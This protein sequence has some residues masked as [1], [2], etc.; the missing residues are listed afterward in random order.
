MSHP[1]AVIVG[2]VEDTGA[3]IY[4]CPECGHESDAEG[5][6]VMGADPG[7]LFCNQCN[8]EFDVP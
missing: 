4:R 6:D 1:V 8:T 5:C 2:E 7:C 3:P